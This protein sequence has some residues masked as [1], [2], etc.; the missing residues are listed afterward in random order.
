VDRGRGGGH[1]DL[2]GPAHDLEREQLPAQQLRVDPGG[3]PLTAADSA[4]VK[5]VVQALAARHVKN[6]LSITAG[7]PSAGPPGGLD[8]ATA[9][10]RRD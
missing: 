9:R 8:P 4:K 6:I 1:R 10:H 3:A 7:P 2:T 5:S